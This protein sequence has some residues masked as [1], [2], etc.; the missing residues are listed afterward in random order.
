MG[1]REIRLDELVGRLADLEPLDDELCISDVPAGRETW[2]SD[3]LHLLSVIGSLGPGELGFG[4]QA[5]GMDW[6]PLRILGP[7]REDDETLFAARE[8]E[9][10]QSC[11]L[12]LLPPA[13]FEPRRVRVDLHH[14]AEVLARIEHPRLTRV[15]GAASHEGRT[16]IW[17][18]SQEGAWL[19][20]LL[21]APLGWEEACDLVLAVA[22]VVV[23]L[24]EH[25]LVHRR[26]DPERIMLTDGGPVLV[27]LGS[28]FGDEAATRLAP[29]V[30]R[31]AAPTVRAD[32]YALGRLLC[33]LVGREPS[34]LS[35]SRLD[36]LL[37]PEPDHRL[38]DARAA[39]D[40]LR[41]LRSRPPDEPERRGLRPL[42]R[43]L[44]WRK[45][46]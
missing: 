45:R 10:G 13:R 11:W 32:V 40:A 12:R 38:A 34:E 7:V 5:P 4:S 6:G 35:R 27:D 17:A 25:G 43:N 3:N 44:S 29:E 31:G 2:L 15:R 23:V 16:G 18:D 46:T 42:W 22:E 9:S 21:D 26:V 39:I 24:H 41:F 36:E 33:Q 19:A 1:R 37:R 30:A 28:D 14:E 8:I 20:D